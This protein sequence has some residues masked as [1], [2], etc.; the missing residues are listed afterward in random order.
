MAE[1]GLSLQANAEQPAAGACPP[2]GR[3]NEVFTGSKVF[4]SSPLGEAPAPRLRA[5]LTPFG[6]LLTRRRAES[7]ATSSAARSAA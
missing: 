4:N 7:V 5:F 2:E 3:K 6:G 1:G